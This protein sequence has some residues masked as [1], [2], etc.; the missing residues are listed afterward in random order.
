MAN[1]TFDI[2]DNIARTRSTFSSFSGVQTSFAVQ[3]AAFAQKID[4][5][6]STVVRLTAANIYSDIVKTWPVDT[7]YSRHN[8]QVAEGE[9]PEG[10]IG[11]P[12]KRK[13]G[14]NGG[15]V[16]EPLYQ[17]AGKNTQLPVRNDA[18]D[19]WIVNNVVYAES[20]ENGHSQQAPHGCVRIAVAAAEEEMANTIVSE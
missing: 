15:P 20:L 8:W 7:G 19:I 16:M 5:N 13:K 3:C 12:E 14:E 11:I 18:I 4:V 1:G 17:P 10:T 6:I 2:N 9:P